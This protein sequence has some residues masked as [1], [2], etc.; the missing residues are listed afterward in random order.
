MTQNEESPNIEQIINSYPIMD[1]VFVHIFRSILATQGINYAFNE[2]IPTDV[3]F[4]ELSA[5]LG[6][7]VE[8]FNASC[9]KFADSDMF[10]YEHA[11]D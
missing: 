6:L 8:S 10:C 7:G 1:T 3:V 11:E 5:L 9:W 2:K 4:S